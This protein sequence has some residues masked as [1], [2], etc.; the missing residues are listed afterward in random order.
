MYSFS[1]ILIGYHLAVMGATG[2]MCFFGNSQNTPIEKII[3]IIASPLAATL[4]Y[5]SYVIWKP[6]IPRIVYTCYF[7]YLLFS[8]YS[9]KSK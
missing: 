8:T 7:S 5:K 4:S 3:A 9:E 1:N 2:I 6:I